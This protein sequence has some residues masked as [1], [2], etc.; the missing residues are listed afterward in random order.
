MSLSFDDFAPAQPGLQSAPP[1]PARPAAAAAPAA[2]D[3]MAKLT[4]MKSMLDAGLITL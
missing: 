3:P 4:P 2:E 1:G